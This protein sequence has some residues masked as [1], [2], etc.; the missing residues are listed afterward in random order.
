MTD[1]LKL[2]WHHQTRK[3]LYKYIKEQDTITTDDSLSQQRH[4]WQKDDVRLQQQQQQQQN[5]LTAC[6]VYS[7]TI[8]TNS[9]SNAHCIPAMMYRYW[10]WHHKLLRRLVPSFCRWGSGSCW[11]R[12]TGTNWTIRAI[13]LRSWLRRDWTFRVCCS[14]IFVY[15]FILNICISLTPWAIKR[16][17]TY[18]CL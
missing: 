10:R 16:S 2:L 12:Y 11:R 15:V 6:K 18:F 4:K 5:T 8:N 1:I 17:R 3:C 9:L 7:I 13:F 14:G